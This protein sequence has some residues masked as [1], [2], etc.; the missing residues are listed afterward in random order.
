MSRVPPLPV[1]V[2]EREEL[3][4]LVRA[5]TT[6]QRLVKRAKVILMAGD[7]VP[8]HQISMA[9]GMGEAYVA[10][11]RQRFEAKRM[12]GLA[13]DP[14]PG[15]PRIYGPEER[16]R[17]VATVT[18]EPPDPASH[19][20]HSQLADTLSE[21]VGISASQIGRILA[22]M[23][24]KP[25]RV[26]YW[27]S[28]R[29][30]PYFWERAADVCGLYLKA[31]DNA[32]VLSVDEKTQIP[33]RSRTQPTTPV[34]PGQAERQENEYVRHGIA[35][36]VTAMDVHG[37]GIFHADGIEANNSTNF[38]S[39]LEEIDAKVPAG[40]EIHVVMDNGSSHVSHQT[41]SWLSEHERFH[42]HHTPAHASWLNM[43][44]LFF[45][46]LS[47]RLINRGVFTS[48]DDMVT[49]V[50]AFIADYNRTAKPF[51]WTYDGSPLRVA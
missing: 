2:E 50:L 14:R 20:S 5:H 6:P 40:L 9:V 24:L 17:L 4:R 47:R 11:W 35:N 1:N 32:V 49:R 33:V 16:L 7:G 15:R 38:C 23:D 18:S 36:L 44:E 25:H 41:Q 8:N 27:I 3:Q 10:K 48:A 21:E 42:V 26:R 37:G 43:V 29:D 31:P 30:D 39:F 13:D 12:D 19:W 28:R 45:S 34:A 51:R 22:A 46:I